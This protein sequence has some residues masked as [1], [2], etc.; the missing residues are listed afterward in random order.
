MMIRPRY[1]TKLSRGHQRHRAPALPWRDQD[2]DRGPVR[3]WGTVLPADEPDVRKQL[4]LWQ[5]VLT[6]APEVRELPVAQ[7]LHF[8]VPRLEGEDFIGQQIH[9][10]ANSAVRRADLDHRPAA[11]VVDDRAAT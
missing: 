11:D 1:Y 10:A 3:V 5:E 7:S 9:E 8:H 2:V 6:L 4:W